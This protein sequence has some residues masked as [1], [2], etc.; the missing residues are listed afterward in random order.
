MPAIRLR[1]REDVP[2][3]GACGTRVPDVG[4]RTDTIR[5]NRVGLR[6]VI[7]TRRSHRSDGGSLALE[8]RTMLDSWIIEEL[9]R[10][11]QTEREHDHAPVLEFPLEDRRVPPNR[12]SDLDDEEERDGGHKRGV[13]VIDL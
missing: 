13:I 6:I 3:I 9:R 10:R 11:E 1:K 4:D 12:K 7:Q 2:T 5:V 8:K